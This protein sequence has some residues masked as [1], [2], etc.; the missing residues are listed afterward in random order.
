MT[1]LKTLFFIPKV[2]FPSITG[3]FGDY[4]VVVKLTNSLLR[5]RDRLTRQATDPAGKI[6]CAEEL[7]SFGAGLLT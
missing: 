4:S 2:D 5:I 6:G 3:G 1:L 7:N